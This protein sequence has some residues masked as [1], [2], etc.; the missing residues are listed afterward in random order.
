[1]SRL[2]LLVLFS[3]LAFLSNG[4]DKPEDLTVSVDSFLKINYWPYCINSYDFVLKFNLKNNTSYPLYVHRDKND[5]YYP[6]NNCQLEDTAHSLFF[7]ADTIKYAQPPDTTGVI[8][9]IDGCRIVRPEDRAD[10]IGGKDGEYLYQEYIRHL[11]IRNN[12]LKQ[13]KIN[14]ERYFIIKPRRTIQVSVKIDFR[15]VDRGYWFAQMGGE[16]EIKKVMLKV[17]MR[18][19][20]SKPVNEYLYP[21]ETKL[22]KIAFPKK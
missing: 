6:C 10:C 13:K 17:K 12:S 3:S 8:Y 7:L 22:F 16:I 9:I 14:N 5:K 11:R 18:N 15:D 19:D 21:L 1:M 20:I 4:Q 2:L